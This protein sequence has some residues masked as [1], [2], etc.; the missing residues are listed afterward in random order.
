MSAVDVSV[1][2]RN[3][4]RGI[5]GNEGSYPWAVPG[6]TGDNLWTIGD[7]HVYTSEGAMACCWS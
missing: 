2:A 3:S 6:V 7:S 5:T 1:G 4:P